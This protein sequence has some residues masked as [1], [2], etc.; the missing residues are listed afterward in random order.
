MK[1]SWSLPITIE[2]AETGLRR[3]VR[4]VRQARSALHRNWP[5]SSGSRFRHAEEACEDALHG[6]RAP[7]DCRKAFIEAAIEA[8]LHLS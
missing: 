8:H 4:T 7:G 3:T 2:N 6:D 5:D 1:T